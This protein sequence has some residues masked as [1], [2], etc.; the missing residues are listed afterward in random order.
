[1]QSMTAFA[2][3][4]SIRNMLG[5][6]TNYSSSVLGETEGNTWNSQMIVDAINFAIRRYA[7]ITHATYISA[8]VASTQSHIMSADGFD[9]LNLPSDNLKLLRVAFPTQTALSSVIYGSGALL[10]TTKSF[11]QI[12]FPMWEE[13]VGVKPR[14]WMKNDSLT[15]RLIP[16]TPASLNFVIGYVQAPV[17]ITTLAAVPAP[18]LRVGQWYEIATAGDTNFTT[19]GAA[20]SN[21][22][23]QFKATAVSA[24]TGTAFEIIDPRILPAHQEYLRYAAS[25]YLIG[26]SSDQQS[27]VMSAKYDA[28]FNQLLGISVK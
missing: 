24:T 11:E 3:E 12:R 7:M 22:G 10:E 18:V 8:T 6:N 17:N 26:M 1:M 16:A 25:A 28:I 27:I 14:K 13:E 4:L 23:T 19:V 5:D 15:V 20:N 9:N 2:F 21:I